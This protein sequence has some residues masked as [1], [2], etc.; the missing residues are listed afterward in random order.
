MPDALAYFG[1]HPETNRSSTLVVMLCFLFS[2]CQ[3]IFLLG[4]MLKYAGIMSLFHTFWR[5]VWHMVL[6]WNADHFNFLCRWMEYIAKRKFYGAISCHFVNVNWPVC[7]S[8]AAQLS[9]TSTQ[10]MTVH[11]CTLWLPVLKL[12]QTR[13]WHLVYQYTGRILSNVMDGVQQTYMLGIE[14][15]YFNLLVQLA[16]T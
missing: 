5:I 10:R 2:K 12:W 1:L 15:F 6:L 4:W 16:D 11:L 7:K 13:L 14:L 8:E 3:P 9:T